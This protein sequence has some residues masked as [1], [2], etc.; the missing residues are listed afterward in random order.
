MD[1]DVPAYAIDLSGINR[2]RSIIGDADGDTNIEV[3]SSPDEDVI[4]FSA[5]GVEYFAL[6]SGRLNVVNTGNSVFI[7]NQAG[8]NDDF[9]DNRNTAIGSTSSALPA[10]NPS[11]SRNNSIRPGSHKPGR[12]G[13]ASA[14]RM[15]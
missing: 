14:K 2:V 11:V 5:G 13:S 8:L 10:M 9:S 6:D 3:E 1:D 15:R 7:G 12:T 4:R